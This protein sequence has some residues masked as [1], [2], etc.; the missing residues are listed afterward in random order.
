MSNILWPDDVAIEYFDFPEDIPVHI[1]DGYDFI[2]N[3]KE[4]YTAIIV[5]AF[6]AKTIPFQLLSVF[7][8]LILVPHL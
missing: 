1:S 5:D 3:S 4:K 8:C 6:T 7:V 2:V